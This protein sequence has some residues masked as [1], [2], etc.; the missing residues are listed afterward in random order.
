M[1]LNFASSDKFNIPRDVCLIF[2]QLNIRIIHSG[3]RDNLFSPDVLKIKKKSCIM[4]SAGINEP[5]GQFRN[6]YQEHFLGGKGGRCLGLTTLPPS[7][8]VVM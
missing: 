7:F 5:T 1:P 3:H 6:E 4:T 8:A 2:N